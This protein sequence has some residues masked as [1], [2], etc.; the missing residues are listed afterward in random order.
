MVIDMNEAQVRT[1]E[2]VRQVLAGTQAIEFQPADDDKGH[3]NESFRFRHSTLEAKSRI[4][5]RESSRKGSAAA[6]TSPTPA[7]EEEPF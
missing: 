5:A 4:K 2:Q 7:Q 3:G 6:T 1:L